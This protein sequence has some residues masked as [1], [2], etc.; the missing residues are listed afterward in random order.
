MVLCGSDQTHCVFKFCSMVLLLCMGSLWISR[1][2]QYRITLP[3]HTM[4]ESCA[5]EGVVAKNLQRTRASIYC[6]A[7][8]TLLYLIIL[9]YSALSRHSVLRA[10][11]FT[12]ATACGELAGLMGGL[13]DDT[14][15]HKVSRNRLYSARM[16][17]QYN[18][19]QHTTKYNTTQYNTRQHTTIQYYPSQH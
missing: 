18:T 17:V 2:N 5:K 7:C 15:L 11:M 1:G 16:E 9:H 13:S 14:W 8:C 10:E 6:S 4:S 3:E 19:I 12:D